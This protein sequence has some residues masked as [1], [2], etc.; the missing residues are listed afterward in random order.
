MINKMK[1]HNMTNKCDVECKM[2]DQWK[3]MSAAVNSNDHCMDCE[4]IA[5]DSL[6]CNAREILMK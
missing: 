2:H 3:M 4:Q 6:Q 1:G 5:N